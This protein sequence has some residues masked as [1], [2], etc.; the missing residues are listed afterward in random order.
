MKR[1]Y[2]TNLNEESL[3]E[4]KSQ[5][6]FKIDIEPYKIVTIKSYKNF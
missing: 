1:L 4:V 6:G 3:I 5:N 2:I